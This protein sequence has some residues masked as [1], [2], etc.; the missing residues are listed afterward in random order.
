MLKKATP[1]V[2]AAVVVAMVLAN[3]GSGGAEALFDCRAEA[4]RPR[5]LQVR[6]RAAM[7]FPTDPASMAAARRPRVD[8]DPRFPVPLTVGEELQMKRRMRLQHAIEDLA[9][10][11]GSA[12]DELGG[13]AFEQVGN[14]AVV[15]YLAPR[16][17]EKKWKQI[18]AAKYRY[19]DKVRFERV[20][21]SA[22]DLQ[23]RA[24]L[25][26]TDLP[27]LKSQGFQITGVGVDVR[28]APRVVIWLADCA[29]AEQLAE[30][31]PAVSFEQR[32]AG[33]DGPGID[34]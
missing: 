26:S 20:E 9:Q 16:A 19:P 30:K 31:Y 14:G 3:R 15:L 7:G 32:E 29:Q 8:A 11:V 22:N 18:V 21:K 17:S 2:A 4:N 24:D 34:L 12:L 28:K 10:S 33:G 13:M 6:Q 5:D 27:E 1:L 25:I 23:Q